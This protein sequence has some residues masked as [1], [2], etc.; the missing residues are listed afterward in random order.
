MTPSPGTKDLFVLVADSQIQR[1]IGTLLSHRVRALNIRYI[2]FDV[3]RHPQ[4]DPGCRT[5]SASLLDTTRD[6]HNK[7]LVVFDFQGCGETR[8][9]APDLERQLEQE[10]HDRGWAADRVAFIVID[11]E[12]EA[13]AFGVAFEHLQRAVGWKGPESIPNW[14]ESNGHLP[15]G[16]GKPADP[17]TALEALLFQSRRTRSGRVYEELARNVGLARCQDRAFQKFRDTL[18]RWFPPPG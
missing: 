9:P 15:G 4:Q 18:R 13:W 7:A 16:M 6:S 2:S 8:L 17:K 12:L 5:A 1:S 11:P 14:L 3:R 10:Y